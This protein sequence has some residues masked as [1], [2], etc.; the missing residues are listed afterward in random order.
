MYVRAEMLHLVHA[1]ARTISQVYGRNTHLHR[2]RMAMTGVRTA[3]GWRR[4]RS[5]TDGEVLPGNEDPAAVQLAE[6]PDPGR[7]LKVVQVPV[8]A[9]L[10]DA[11]ELAE[12]LERAGIDQRVDT[13]ADRQLA[14]PALTRDSLRA[15]HLLG[16]FVPSLYLFNLWL[17]Y[18]EKY[19]L[20][21]SA[22]ILRCPNLRLCAYYLVVRHGLY[23]ALGHPQQLSQDVLVVLPQKGRGLAYLQ[24]EV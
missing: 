14:S 15:A 8:L 19:L 1:A 24:W 17:P 18:H 11:L 20:W 12:L 7:G 5:A 4:G 22:H 3:A 16:Q 21:S 23:L 2:G 10:A 9:V 13:L 6:S